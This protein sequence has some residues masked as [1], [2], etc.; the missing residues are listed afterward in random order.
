LRIADRPAIGRVVAQI[1]SDRGTKYVTVEE[2]DRT[3]V[4]THPSP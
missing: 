2:G 1:L 4:S 3:P